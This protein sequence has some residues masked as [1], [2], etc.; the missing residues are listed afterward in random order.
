MTDYDSDAS[1]IYDK[2]RYSHTHIKTRPDV[3][4]DVVR[5][6]K[7]TYSDI[8]VLTSSSDVVLFKTADGVFICSVILDNGDDEVYMLTLVEKSVNTIIDMFDYDYD[9]DVTVPADTKIDINTSID[10][11]VI[12][13][14]KWNI[15]GLLEG[16]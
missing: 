4:S 15:E 6:V 1:E 14:Y 12:S 2:Y 16:L 10:D 5:I 9:F 7:A 13:A 3:I 11:E 8:S